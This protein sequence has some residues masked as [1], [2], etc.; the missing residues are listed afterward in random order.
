MTWQELENILEKHVRHTIT[1]YGKPCE[2]VSEASDSCAVVEY[3]CLDCKRVFMVIIITIINNFKAWANWSVP[4]QL[5][6]Q[7]VMFSPF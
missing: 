7:L 1:L 3:H 2:G 5:S 4:R 6:S